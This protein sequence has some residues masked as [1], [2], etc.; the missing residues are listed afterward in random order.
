MSTVNEKLTAIADAIRDKTK[1]TAPLSLDDM[2]TGIQNI[3]T[4]DNYY[5]TFWEAYQDVS[6]TGKSQITSAT[7]M[8][9]GRSWKDTTFKPK[10]SMYSITNANQMFAQCGVTDMAGRMKELGL[11]FDYAKVTG[12][13]TQMYAYCLCTTIPEI[14]S[15]GGSGFTQTFQQAT[16]LQ[17]IE[18][19]ILK[20]DGSQSFSNT[21]AACESL[22]NLTFAGANETDE[23]NPTGFIGQ[24]GLDLSPAKKLSKASI[25]NVIKHLSSTASGKTVT[26]SLAAVNNAFET[27]EGAADGS[28]SDEWRTLKATK[29]NWTVSLV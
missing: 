24:N 7:Y 23:N 9:G 20:A 22:V 27:S 2:A 26:F 6:S 19:I 18:K 16:K 5:D 28:A 10:Y 21:F 12:A 11:V 8:F 13:F 1:T 25:I 14:N 29:S 3:S 4:G 17:T 15:I